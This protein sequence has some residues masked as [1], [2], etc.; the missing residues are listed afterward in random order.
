MAHEVPPSKWATAAGAW[1]FLSRDAV[2]RRGWECMHFD[3]FTQNDVSIL[4]TLFCILLFSH[5]T[6]HLY[7][8]QEHLG[9]CFTLYVG[10]SHSFRVCRV[11]HLWRRHYF[12]HGPCFTSWH[13]PPCSTS[14]LYVRPVPISTSADLHCLPKL[15]K[16][17]YNDWW[18][19][20]YPLK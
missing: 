5:L 2:G 14:A 6:E 12:Q 17:R 11:F 4:Y 1:D 19:C 20:E 18:F 9:K 15:V 7:L 16:N 13:T 8:L 3:F 10:Q